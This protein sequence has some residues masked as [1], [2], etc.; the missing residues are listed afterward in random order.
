MHRSLG[1][2]KICVLVHGL[3]CTISVRFTLNI[4]LPD[5]QHDGLHSERSPFL[6]GIGEHE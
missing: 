4:T 6:D 1:E 2:V 5:I 3:C